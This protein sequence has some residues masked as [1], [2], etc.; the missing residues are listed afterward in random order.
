MQKLIVKEV[1]DDKYVLLD[2]TTKKKYEFT[3]TFY[4]IDE[5]V[6]KGDIL[7][8]QP[9]LLNPFYEEYSF[10]YMIGGINSPE[11]RKITSEKDADLIFL[12]TQNNT[13]KL[14][15]LWG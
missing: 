3:L 1:I 10:Y 14:K 13:Y 2:I 15:R 11:G 9:E 12:K 4:D 5:P 6:Q 7:G 8:I